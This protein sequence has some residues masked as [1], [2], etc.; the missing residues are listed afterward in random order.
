MASLR[1]SRGVRSRIRTPSRWSI[2]CWMTRASRP[3]ASIDD[4]L[5]VRVLRA[6]ADVDRPLDVDVD[7][8]KAQAALLH[9]LLL[10]AR[11]LQFGVDQRVD[12]A[13]VLDAVDED[14]VQRADL[15]R[16]EADAHRVVHERGHPRDLVAQRVVEDL[17]RPGLRAEHRIAE[18]AHV[19][20]RRRAAR[21]ELGIE[22]LLLGRV[23]DDFGVVQVV[24]HLGAK[25]TCPPSGGRMSD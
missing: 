22:A 4:R 23:L 11:P 6:D 16:G 13:V 17:D 8:G 20:E 10:L 15:G 25:G 3:D 18:L 19:R 7:A 5:A 12:R 21:G 1:W 9:P 2:S 24:R 14:A